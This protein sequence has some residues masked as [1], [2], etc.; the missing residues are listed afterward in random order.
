MRLKGGRYA[1]G[2]KKRDERKMHWKMTSRM[3][4]TF[5]RHPAVHGKGIGEGRNT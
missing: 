5:R 2:Q 1:V 4:P 3:T